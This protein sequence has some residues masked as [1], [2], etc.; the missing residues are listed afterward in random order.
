V[1]TG[2]E[3]QEDRDGCILQIVLN[4]GEGPAERVPETTAEIPQAHLHP[5]SSRSGDAAHLQHVPGP[6]HGHTHEVATGKKSGG[7][8][9]RID[10]PGIGRGEFL[11]MALQPID[12]RIKRQSPAVGVLYSGEFLVTDDLPAGGRAE[13]LPD[14]VES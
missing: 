11:E 4:A 3:G 6:R 1:H 8:D 5:F 7:A 14:P 12:I 9:V 10:Y 2:Q 13:F